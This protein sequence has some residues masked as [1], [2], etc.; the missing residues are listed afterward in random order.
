MVLHWS[1]SDIKSPHVSRTLLSILADLGNTVVWMVLFHQQIS[2]FSRPLSKRFGTV[3]ITIGITVIFM[4][5]LFFSPLARSKY[6]SLFV[7][8]DFHSGSARFCLLSGI[9]WS[10]SQRILC[11]I[12]QHWFWFVSVSFDSMI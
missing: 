6:L 3:I 1:L 10:K 2:N 11:L 5:S 8:F 4:F 7:F 12:I 9:R